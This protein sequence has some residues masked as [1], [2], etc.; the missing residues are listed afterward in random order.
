MVVSYELIIHIMDFKLNNMIST[1]AKDF[2]WKEW[3]KFS[4]LKKRKFARFQ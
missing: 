4:R 2:A 1:Y 3:P